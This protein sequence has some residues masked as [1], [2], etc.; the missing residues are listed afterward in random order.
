MA[1][2]IRVLQSNEASVTVTILVFPCCSQLRFPFRAQARRALESAVCCFCCS[3]CFCSRLPC[4]HHQAIGCDVDQVASWQRAVMV[5][6]FSLVLF[7]VGGRNGALV[8]SKQGAVTFSNKLSQARRS[9]RTRHWFH[10]TTQDVLRLGHL[11][12]HGQMSG[13]LTDANEPSNS[14]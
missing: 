12:I 1:A 6:P 5:V 10:D 3:A 8:A 14:L 13:H 11:T 7:A 2:F 9:R 4:T